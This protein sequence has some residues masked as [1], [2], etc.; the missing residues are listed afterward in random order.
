MNT[1]LFARLST[2]LLIVASLFAM[3]VAATFAAEAAPAQPTSGAV[4]S[5]Q[6]ENQLDTLSEKLKTLARPIAGFA[7]LLIALSFILAP[8]F[9]EWAMENKR[10]MSTVIFGIVLIGFSGELVALFFE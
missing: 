4:V 9:K 8:A 2:L 5:N 10:T 6:I 1:T 3:P 7:F